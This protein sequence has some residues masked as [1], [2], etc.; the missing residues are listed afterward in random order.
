MA[1]QRA[2]TFV[3]W[4]ATTHI[5]MYQT[6]PIQV[7]AAA[8]MPIQNKMTVAGL[9]QFKSPSVQ[10]YYGSP[11]TYELDATSYALG[12][13]SGGDKSYAPDT[14]VIKYKLWLENL[15]PALEAAIDRASSDYGVVITVDWFVYLPCVSKVAWYSLNLMTMAAKGLMGSGAGLSNFVKYDMFI[16]PPCATDAIQAGVVTTVYPAIYVT[17]SVTLAD[18]LSEYPNA[19][20]CNWSSY[21]QWSIFLAMAA[22]HEWTNLA[23][24]YDDSD[25]TQTTWTNSLINR[26]SAVSGNTYVPYALS[27]N[28]ADIGSL[29]T[30]A[31]SQARGAGNT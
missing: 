26:W 18:T 9:K 25:N 24:F 15:R 14:A 20:R 30:A 3:L 12:E 23:L 27:S 21:T 28:T 22:K 1:W 2:W 17:G 13:C 31:R 29:L 10:Q 8:F 4:T 11:S 6:T 7:R 16:G 19:V 5:Q